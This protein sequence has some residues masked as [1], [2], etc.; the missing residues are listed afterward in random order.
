M[1]PEL[2]GEWSE[3]ADNVTFPFLN[4]YIYPEV[5]GQKKQTM[6]QYSRFYGVK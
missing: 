3:E 4:A 5:R 1:Y 2:S 6:S